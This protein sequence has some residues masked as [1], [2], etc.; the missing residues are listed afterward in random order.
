MANR[1]KGREAWANYLESKQLPVLKETLGKILHITESDRATVSRLA[2]VVLD[3]ADLATNVLKLANSALYNPSQASISTVSRAI[4]VIGFN[5]V[6]SM[7]VTSLLV[8]RMA[9]CKQRDSLYRCLAKSLHSAVQAKYLA[10]DFPIATQEEIFVAALLSNLS[11]AAFW[12]CDHELA[13]QLSRHPQLMASDP[14]QTQREFLGTTFKTITRTIAKNWNLGHLIEESLT[15]PHSRVAKVVATACAIANLF[16]QAGQ[17]S[18]PL[19]VDKASLKLCSE[20]TNQNPDVVKKALRENRKIAMRMA[21]T[22]GIKQVTRFLEDSKQPAM[23]TCQPNPV[24]QIECLQKISMMQKSRFDEKAVDI[25]LYALH[26][27]MGFERAGVFLSRCSPEGATLSKTTQFQLLQSTGAGQHQW[28]SGRIFQTA[29]Q[30]PVNKVFRFD[31]QNI[32]PSASADLGDRL[33]APFADK[34]IPA[35]AALLPISKGYQALIYADRC[36]LTDI[37]AEQQ[38]SL[39]L[40]VYTLY[41]RMTLSLLHTDNGMLARSMRL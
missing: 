39:E 36:S 25:V 10:K 3:D 7:T 14:A 32:A 8:D 28:F 12:A 24:V 34:T 16:D 35:L 2:E 22:L 27:G 30:L 5:S 21:E 41:A 11:E 26:Q 9:Q 33:E 4:M 38:L 1:M 23:E 13:E 20:F 17:M 15:Q 6:K 19:D 29:R 37:T 31:E 40:M 18:L